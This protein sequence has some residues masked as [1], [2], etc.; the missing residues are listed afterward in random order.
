MKK[1][2]FHSPLFFFWKRLL[3][4]NIGPEY[5]ATKDFLTPE[6]TGLTLC[7]RSDWK[8]ILQNLF[9]KFHI[10]VFFSGSNYSRSNSPP[11]YSL[12]L[13]MNKL[14]PIIF[15]SL[16]IYS[17]LNELDTFNI[18]VPMT[19][20]FYFLTYFIKRFAKRYLSYPDLLRNSQFRI[21][22]WWI[23]YF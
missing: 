16:T 18:K 12:G 6:L 4:L 5:Q 11:S 8:K 7:Q 3:Y 21:P 20:L 2:E 17:K 10:L 23:I 13:F 22:S 14:M 15:T 9:F 1:W 19:K